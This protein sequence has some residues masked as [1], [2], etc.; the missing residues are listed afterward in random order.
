[1]GERENE[2]ADH[3]Y[4]VA[5]IVYTSNSCSSWTKSNKSVEAST[6]GKQSLSRMCRLLKVHLYLSLP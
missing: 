2:T 6:N 1:M 4:I 5:E 3:I